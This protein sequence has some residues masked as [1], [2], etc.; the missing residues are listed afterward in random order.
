MSEK[1]LTIEVP[2]YEEYL[3]VS[4]NVVTH[5][6]VNV[7]YMEQS[8]QLKKRYS[9]FS[10]LHFA[11][12]D[13]FPQIAVFKF[14]NKSIFNTHS[15]YTKDRRRQG[16]DDFVKVVATL[17]P[18]PQEVEIFLELDAEDDAGGTATSDIISSSADVVWSSSS[19]AAGASSSSSSA[20]SSSSSAT[21]DTSTTNTGTNSSKARSSDRRRASES[22]LPK[23]M[24]DLAVSD[25]ENE[26]KIQRRDFFVQISPSSTFMAAGAYASLVAAN[27]IDISTTTTGMFLSACYLVTI[28]FVRFL[29]P[30]DFACCP[31]I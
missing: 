24:V 4:S 25:H 9:E 29:S 17:R 2:T 14:P 3:D 19:A 22:K 31:N 18:I 10:N 30:L 15:Q 13:R 8:F 21:V 16:V 27:V 26:M 7:V 23:G 12:K 28:C 11:L 5:Y 20:S 6:V 1:I